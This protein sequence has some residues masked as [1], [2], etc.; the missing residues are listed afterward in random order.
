MNEP[1]TPTRVQGA[2]VA[3]FTAVWEAAPS[4]SVRRELEDDFAA[5]HPANPVLGARHTAGDGSSVIE[6]T[7]L[8]RLPETSSIPH[9]VMIHINS[10]TDAHREDISPALLTRVGESSFWEIT[11]LLPVDLIASYRIVVGADHPL[12]REGGHRRSGW[13]R[14]HELGRP[15]PRGVET[16][17][18]PLGTHS[19]VLT[20]PEAERHPVWTGS[21][22]HHGSTLRRLDIPTVDGATRTLHVYRPHGADA[23]HNLL[24]LFDGEV[25]NEIGLQDALDRWDGEPL[26]AVL[27]S[28]VSPERR[29]ADL[30]H[31]ERIARIV[32]DEVLPAA[33]VELGRSYTADQ[34][35][36]SGQSYGGLASAAI[37]AEY[38]G[39]AS[40]GVAQSPS[41][42]FRANEE[43]RR[44]EG[45]RGDVSSRLSSC[46]THGKL[47]ITVGRNEGGLLDQARVARNTIAETN[48]Q[49]DYV[50][51]MGGH[52]YAWWRDGLFWGLDK[53]LRAASTGPHPKPSPAEPGHV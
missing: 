44:P 4:G 1:R 36:V 23:P 18:N 2:A 41:F 33:F 43:P 22:F 39:I 47:V 13:L 46:T 15:D 49:L 12:P 31:P 50:E 10:V 26:A 27:V 32:Q 19:S 42:H 6:T 11:Y 35:I 53:L 52:D 48:L 7:F 8:W 9:D 17:P 25:W 14:I 24:V 30:P 16:L 28:S 40:R 38:P 37:V 34:T 45:Q 3:A 51:I 20:L 29:S 5:A 21:E